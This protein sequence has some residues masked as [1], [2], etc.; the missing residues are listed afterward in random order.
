M[1]QETYAHAG[2]EKITAGAHESFWT[3]STYPLAYTKLSQNIKTDVVIV[4]GGIAGISI[5]YALTLSGKRVAIIEDGFI[6]SGETGR[7]TAHLASALDDRYYD[8]ERMF[9]EEK[10]KLIAESHKSAID[11]IEKTINRENIK[12]DFERVDGYLFLHPTDDI[13]SLKKEYDAA[14]KAGLVVEQLDD[15]PGIK[16][17]HGPCL[18]FPNQGQF[19]PVKYMEALC[20]SIRFNGGVIYTNT[21]A[22]EIDHTGVVT[23]DGFKVS[24]DHVVIATNTPV[25]NKYVIHLKQFPYRTYVIAA[26]IKRESLPTYLWWDTG[27]FEANPDITPYHY[28]RTQKFDTTHDLLIIGGEDHA[29]GLADM[30]DRPEEDR[31]TALEKWA[32]QYFDF[33]EIIYKWSGQVMEPMDSIAYIGRNPMDKKNVYIVTGDSGNGMTHATIAAMLIDDLINGHENKYEKLYDPSRLKLFTAGKVLFKEFTGGLKN[34][35]KAMEKDSW[36][37]DLEKIQPNEGKVIEIASEKYGVYCDE[38]NHL[39][40]VGAECTHLKCTVRWNND[41]KSWDCPCHGSRFTYNGKVLNGPANEE[42][43]YYK[44]DEIKSA[45]KPE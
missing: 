41:E 31:Y 18:R 26:K 20:E 40:F 29:T 36:Q 11:F 32:R 1:E 7:T 21:H 30:E 25:N 16:N 9:G 6:G 3:S 12:C 10:T 2:T 23:A 13:E 38:H 39:H 45:K 4:G 15:V 8:L 44:D 37:N 42:L 24:A 14:T 19:H 34:Y 33:E 43:P 17:N 22:Q 27:D 35:F 5:G 28:V